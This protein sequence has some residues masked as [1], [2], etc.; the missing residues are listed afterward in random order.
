MT[1]VPAAMPDTDPEASTVAL[2]GTVL[3]QV[4]PV[5]AP[6]S[7]VASPMQ[8][9][10]FPAI[11]PGTALTVIVVVANAVKPFPSVTVTV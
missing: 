8:T 2:A 7:V 10:L 3:S 5:G 6:V 9:L 1:V 4:P 11:G